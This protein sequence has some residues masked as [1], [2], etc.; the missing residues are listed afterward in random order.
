MKGSKTVGRLPAKTMSN[1]L[2]DHLSEHS[3]LYVLYIDIQSCLAVF[4]FQKAGPSY[5]P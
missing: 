3:E 4:F 5:V 2:P 1:R